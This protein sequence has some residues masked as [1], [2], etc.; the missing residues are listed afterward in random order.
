MKMKLRS[1]IFNNCFCHSIV[2]D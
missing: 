1:K 2:V